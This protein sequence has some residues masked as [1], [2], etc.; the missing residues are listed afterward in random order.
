MGQVLYRFPVVYDMRKKFFV[1]YFNHIYAGVFADVG[2]AWN[3]QSLNW[4]TKGYVSDAGVELRVDSIS[5]YNFPTM[6]QLSAAYGPDDTWMKYF[7]E[8]R[9]GTSIPKKDDQDPWKFYV[10]VLFGF[11]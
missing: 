7:D 9:L 10:S 3:K 8:D 5:F 4:S 6:L 11:D 1:W 2:R